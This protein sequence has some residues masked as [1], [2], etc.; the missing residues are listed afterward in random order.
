MIQAVMIKYGVLTWLARVDDAAALLLPS[1]VAVG[2]FVKAM[3]P[4]NPSKL[5]HKSFGYPWQGKLQSESGVVI[6]GASLEQ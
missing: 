4:N 6:P 2:E 3:Y 1:T 5:P